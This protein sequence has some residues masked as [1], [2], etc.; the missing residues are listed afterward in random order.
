MDKRKDWQKSLVGKNK[1]GENFFFAD[2][3]YCN[4]QS[5]L[6]SVDIGVLK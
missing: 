1:V 5:L 6:T 3:F 4:L 2:S